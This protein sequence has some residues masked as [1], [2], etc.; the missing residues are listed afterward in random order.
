ML[1]WAMVYLKIKKDIPNYFIG[2]ALF[3]DAVIFISMFD[4]EIIKISFN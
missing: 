2:W 4:S 1:T 3:L